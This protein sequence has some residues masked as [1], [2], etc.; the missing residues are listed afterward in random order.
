MTQTVHGVLK[1]V[2]SSR[3]YS[4][5][6]KIVYGIQKYIIIYCIHIYICTWSKLEINPVRTCTF[7]ISYHVNIVIGSS[8]YIFINSCIE[9]TANKTI[10]K[11][12]FRLSSGATKGV[13]D[14]ES[15]P[16]PYK[17][18]L[19]AQ[20]NNNVYLRQNILKEKLIR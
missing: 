13:V 19:N 17:N 7:N 14:S 18:L 16:H 2:C 15:G 5:I 20:K 6:Y 10:E 4:Y 12:L 9:K 8:S 11:W 1:C 3:I